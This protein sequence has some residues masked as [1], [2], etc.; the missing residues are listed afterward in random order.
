MPIQL[1]T[2]GT[3]V[4][5]KVWTDEVESQALDQLK[6]TASLPFVFKHVAAMP[7]V[8]LGKGATV[9]SVVAT[10]GALIP[11]AIG[12][13]I[14]CGMIAARLSLGKDQKHNL[15]DNLPAVRQLI[16]ATVPVGHAQHKHPVGDALYIT[17]TDLR[18][19]AFDSNEKARCQMGTLGGGNHFIEVCLDGDGRVWI[20]LHSG[21]RNIGKVVAER[22]IDKA[23][24][25]MS[26]W[27]YKVPDPDLAYLPEATKEFDDY[28][29]D[30]QW[31]QEYAAQNRE[32]MLK[33]VLQ[34]LPRYAG[35]VTVEQR[36]N[37]H[38][39]YAA[40]EHHYGE[41][42]YVTR[43]GAIRARQGDYG[44]IPGSMGARSYIV[45]GL[46]CPDSFHSCAHGAG[47]KHSRGE[48]RRR[49]TVDQLQEQTAGVE[50]RKDAGVIDE[51]PAA[52]KDIEKVMANQSDL[53]EIV[54]ELKQ[55]L[56]V[57]G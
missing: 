16:E 28:W 40:L 3:H 53:V 32:E 19:S 27:K 18:V 39:N 52:Y 41:N 15:L 17:T 50:C 10:K 25:L 5:V 48:A 20:V 46:G 31:C 1:V 47:R 44:I 22:H 7:D 13:D 42:V 38:H 23:K 57:K 26:V 37:C 8:H 45:R 43:K 30:L 55:V 33:L 35:H 34:Q 36:I 12:V 14:G 54:A 51:I 29:H 24:Y 49:F 2:K 9:G 4:P 6:N 21:S 11:A 56:C